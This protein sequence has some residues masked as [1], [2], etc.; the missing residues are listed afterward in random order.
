[1]S[2]NLNSAMASGLA[3]GSVYPVVLVLLTF[4]TGVRY[5]WSGVGSL[6]YAGNT[7]VGVGALGTISAVQEGTEVHAD[8]ITVALSGID[9]ALLAECM[10]DIRQGAPA[11][12]WFGLLSNGAILGAPYLIFSG[13][14]DKP[15][16]APGADEVTI[17]L[18]CESRMVNGQRARNRRYTAADQHLDYPTD[19]GMNWVEE[20]NDIAEIWG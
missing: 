12:V 5:V 6:V 4:R 14:V 2:R 16:I 7:Y 17:S 8:G 15:T 18:A 20:M 10:T 1:M 3:G 11:K 13:Q 19:T 9:P